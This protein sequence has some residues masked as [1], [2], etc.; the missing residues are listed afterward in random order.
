MFQFCRII[1]PPQSAVLAVGPVSEKPIVENGE[2]TV[3][4]MMTATLSA[5]HELWMA[6]R[7]L[8]S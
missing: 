3:A 7:E 4:Q 1:H 2:I 5:D 6:Q 8:N